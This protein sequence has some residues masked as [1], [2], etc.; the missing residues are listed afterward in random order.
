MWIFATVLAVFLFF[1]LL[2]AI[3]VDVVFHVEKNDDFRSRIR[4]RWLFG[5]IGKDIGDREKK[6][7]KKSRKKENRGKRNLK[8]F[9]KMWKARG[10]LPKLL[11]F[12]RDALRL[13]KIRELKMSL[14]VGLDDPADT[15]ML[16]AAAGPSAL[17]LRRF[18]SLDMQ[19]EPDF[20]QEDLRGYLQG[21]MRIIPIKFIRPARISGFL[22]HY[23]ASYEDNNWSSSKMKERRADNPIR[24]GEITIIPLIEL[25]VNHVY[26]KKYGLMIHISNVPIGIAIDSPQGI[27][28]IDIHGTEVPLD[29]YIREIPGLQN[30]LFKNESL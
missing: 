23:P 4:V 17:F 14:R 16:F 3:P 10:F 13:V 19:I 20:E 26:N 7:D 28:A 15:G 24:V 8:T 1:V 22:V 2:L 30:I 6:P 5:L 27:W 25:S 18:S 29:T 11:R 21:D 12:I 9:L